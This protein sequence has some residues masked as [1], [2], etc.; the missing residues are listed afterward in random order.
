[1]INREKILAVI[2]AYDE[3]NKIGRVV[4]KIPGDAVDGILVIDDGSKD[5]T[6]KEAAAG[7]AVVLRNEITQGVGSAIRMGINYARENGYAIIVVLAGND[8]DDPQEIKELVRPITE[9]NYDFIQG[10]RYLKGGRYG[11]MPFYRLL[12]TRWVHPFLFSL[13]TRKRIT[14]STNGFRAFRVSM[15]KKINLDQEWL[16]KYE[17][18]PYLFYKAIKL[19]YRVDEIPVTKIY[20]SKQMGY[21]KMKP[22]TGWW[23]ILRPIVLLAL[24]IET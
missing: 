9:K 14:D 17:L 7:G 13:L 21:T 4:G 2:P 24:G 22:I 20:P 6:G 8:K 15:L 3:E 5:N 23:S 19:K 1:M 11:K 10:S 16:E 12:A 18:E